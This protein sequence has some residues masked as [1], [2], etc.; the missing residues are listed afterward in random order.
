MPQFTGYANEYRQ[1][2]DLNLEAVHHLEQ[3]YLA[4]GDGKQ[5]QVWLNRKIDIHRRMGTQATDRA[6]FLAAEAQYVLAV[7]E[8]INFDV[9]RL[10]HPLPKS[11]KRKQKALASTVKAFEAVADYQIARFSTASTFQIADLYT[12][13][14]RAIMDSDRPEDL[15]ELELEQYEIL[16]EEQAFPFE[17]Q[18]ISL[19]EIN[20]RRSW[21]GVYDEWVQKSFTELGRLMPA[22][23]DKQEIDVCLR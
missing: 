3:I 15:T 23:F 12:S 7:E 18:A 13:L 9:I 6:T 19:H 2:F 10:T 11:L 4:R 14:S 5:R 1:P 16:L 21:E 20:M 17:E 8:R 22:R